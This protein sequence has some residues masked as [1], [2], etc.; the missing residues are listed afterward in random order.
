MRRLEDAVSGHVVDIA[1]GSDPDAPD[2]RRQ[3]IGQV[4][5]VQVRGRD[6]VELV[7]PGED[8]LEGYVRY[9]VLHQDL[10][11]GLATAVLPADRHVGEL[12]T[13]DLVTPVAE[14]PLGE[15]LDVPLVHERDAPAVAPHG[16][17][18]RGAH[19]ALRTGLRYRLDA[20]SRVGP[21][22]PP[23]LLL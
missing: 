19:E 2:L 6:D 21:Y 8:L 15:L 23:E 17:L 5:P 7:G 13:G 4:V 14:R 10:V 16:V 18:Q 20:D 11:A 12:V 3:R 9:R 22:R 1:A